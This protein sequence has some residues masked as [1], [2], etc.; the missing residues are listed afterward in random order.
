MPA[1]ADEYVSEG[2]AGLS[3]AL[4][5]TC[6][7]IPARGLH[8]TVGEPPGT[9]PWCLLLALA[10]CTPARHPRGVCVCVSGPCWE[11]G[12]G[13]GGGGQQFLTYLA[14]WLASQSIATAVHVGSLPVDTLPR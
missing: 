11:G 1:V 4:W 6:E 7:T 2:T 14:G 9:G 3:R 8:S 10:R 5:K 13:G 12:G